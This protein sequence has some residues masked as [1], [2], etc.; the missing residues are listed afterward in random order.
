MRR[1]SAITLF[2]VAGAG[3]VLG[4]L[5]AEDEGFAV[6]TLRDRGVLLVRTDRDTLKRTEITAAG[7]IRALRDGTDDRA[8][9]SFFFHLQTPSL[10]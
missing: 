7:M 5:H 9:R 3:V 6:G 2:A 10:I 1:R 4:G 8:V